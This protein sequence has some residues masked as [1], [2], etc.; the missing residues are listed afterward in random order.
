VYIPTPG[1]ELAL[2]RWWGRWVLRGRKARP[3]HLL[4]GGQSLRYTL[5]YRMTAAVTFAMFTG[6]YI[7][8]FAKGDIFTT[9]TLTDVA[10]IAGSALIWLLFA[11]FFVTS[12]IER[13]VITPTQVRRRSW[14]GRQEIVWGDVSFVRIDHLN[15]GV[16][17]GA[18][19]GVVIDVSF[20]LDGLAALADA[21][22]QHQRLPPGFHAVVLSDQ[23]SRIG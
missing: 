13:V 12:Q 19:G 10:V 17:L 3:E 18:Q 20:F 23:A 9:R 5:R 11:F 6:L 15:A 21:L 7:L 4:D 2:L 16:K 14:G 1:V 22:Q 8:G